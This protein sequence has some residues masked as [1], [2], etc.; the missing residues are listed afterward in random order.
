M[1]LST[2]QD[3]AYLKECLAFHS[4]RYSYFESLGNL[5][6]V[7]VIARQEKMAYHLKQVKWFEAKLRSPFRSSPVPQPKRSCLPAADDAHA[8]YLERLALYKS[9]VGQDSFAKA[10]DDQTYMSVADF[11]NFDDFHEPEPVK[12]AGLIARL[13]NKIR[14][15]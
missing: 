2:T 13:W 12:P 14:G 6:P 10:F 7:R 5:T 11:A 15:I 1:K 9:Q 4:Q 8:R 3:V